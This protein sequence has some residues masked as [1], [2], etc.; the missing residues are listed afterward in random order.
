VKWTDTTLHLSSAPLALPQDEGSGKGLAEAPLIVDEAAPPT[1]SPA[2]PLL[3]TPQ[4][5]P[6][7]SA[8]LAHRLSYPEINSP[9]RVCHSA[10]APPSDAISTHD[11][12]E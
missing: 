6:P 5:G 10:R 12:E 11:L 3:M 9:D 4:R 7:L 2:P 8:D 1:S